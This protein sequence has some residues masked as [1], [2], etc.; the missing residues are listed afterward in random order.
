MTRPLLFLLLGMVLL[1]G[2]SCKKDGPEEAEGLSYVDGLPYYH[3]T[4]Q[5]QLWLRT[6]QGDKWTFENGQG[7]QHLYTANVTQYLQHGYRT[8]AP[9]AL[10]GTKY[11][12]VSYYDEA[13][14]NVFSPDSSN[15]GNGG[16][17]HF[18]RDATSRPYNEVGTGPSRLYVEGDWNKFIGNTDDLSDYANCDGMK[19]PTG[20]ELNGPFMQ[21]N[22]RGKQ[23][24]DVIQFRARQR[25][26]TCKR[27]NAASLTELYYDRQ[28]GLVRMVSLA[29]EVWDRVP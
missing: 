7:V 9:Y 23:Y 14:L 11:T 15:T 2:N 18:Y 29:G 1:S 5:D 4:D 24:S 10:L 13:V 12:L 8:F 16:E 26:Q 6:K 25:P 27:P 17:F 19:F 28:A 20:N 3:F 22:V 21:L